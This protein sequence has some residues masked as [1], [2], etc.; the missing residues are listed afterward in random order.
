MRRKMK[1]S[2]WASMAEIVSGFAIVVT[3]IVLI[4]ETRENTRATYSASYDQ[5]AAEMVDWRLA[6]AEDPKLRSDYLAYIGT[7]DE[8]A[9]YSSAGGSMAAEALV[10][11]YERAYFARTYGALGDSEWDRYRGSICSDLTALI[12]PEMKRNSRLTLEFSEFVEN[13]TGSN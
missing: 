10:L 3:L 2:D 8:P 5:L 1:L 11:I 13:C 6:L 7:E 4:V 12:I 9:D